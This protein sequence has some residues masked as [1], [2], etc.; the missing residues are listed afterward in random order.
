MKTSLNRAASGN[1]AVH[2]F[3]RLFSPR[4]FLWR[5]L[6]TVEIVTAGYFRVCLRDKESESGPVASCGDVARVRPPQPG[7]C[8]IFQGLTCA[9]GSL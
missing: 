2:G 8:R 3:G 4:C 1:G 6:P 5:A 9:A 7:F